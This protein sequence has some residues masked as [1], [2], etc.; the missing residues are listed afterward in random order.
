MDEQNTPSLR[1]VV[2][3]VVVVSAV[4]I[5]IMFI[6]TTLTWIRTPQ[7]LY[8]SRNYL[9]IL[10]I[11]AILMAILLISLPF[12][13]PNRRNIVQS[14]K[15][16][17][18][19]VT[20]ALLYILGFNIVIALIYFGAKIIVPAAVLF[21]F[22]IMIVIWGN[23]FGKM[24]RG[25]LMGFRTPWT[26]ASELSWDKTHRLVGRLFIA[27]GLFLILLSAFIG[28]RPDWVYLAIMIGGMFGICI[29]GMVYSYLVWKTDPDRQPARWHQR[30]QGSGYTDQAC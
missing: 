15:G 19:A 28:I 29:Y 24:R 7:E 6:I 2:K 17:T 11:I 3:K 26:F 13:S 16:Y 4:I 22:G 10:P 27:F 14:A 12:W 20:A 18:S 21:L 1:S 9:F 5:G 25:F 30:P 23:Y 8:G